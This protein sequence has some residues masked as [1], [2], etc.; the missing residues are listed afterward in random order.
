MRTSKSTMPFDLVKIMTTFELNDA[1]E[2][3]DLADWLNATFVM[4]ALEEQILNDIYADILISGEYMN[5]EELKARVVALIF[6]AAKIDVPNKIRVFYERPLSATIQNHN[7]AV[8]SDCMVA[9]PLKSMPVKPY[10]FLQEFKKA[11]GEKKDP[12]A[13][14]LVAMLIAQEQN[15]DEKPIF[16]G[17]MIGTGFHFSTLVEKNYCV[18]QKLEATRHEDLI[19]IVFVLRQLKTIILNR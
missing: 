13:Q 3:I 16:G 10:F 2:C 18:S 19:R 8:I 9:S 5:E 17:Y 4:N 14:M 7:L 11:K 6:Y 15:A 12:E 1:Q